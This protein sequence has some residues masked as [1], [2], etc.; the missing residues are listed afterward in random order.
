MTSN[1]VNRRGFLKVAGITLGAS[2]VACGGL[3]Y[4]ASRPPRINLIENTYGEGNP[5]NNHILVTYATRAGSTAEVADAIGETLAARGYVVDVKPIK[6]NPSLEGYQAVV[7]G[8]AIRIAGWLSEA[9]KFVQ[10]NQAELNNLQVALFSVHL[11]NLGEDEASRANREAYTAP[12]RQLLPSAQEAF[13]A[14]KMDLSTVSF[15][16]RTLLKA[17]GKTEGSSMGDHR[18]WDLIRAWAERVFA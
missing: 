8:S 7:I 10:N 2:A 13:F 18:D 3:G 15:L 9:V 11:E 6:E 4:L 1:K 5:A 12:V 16:D 17:M 14:G